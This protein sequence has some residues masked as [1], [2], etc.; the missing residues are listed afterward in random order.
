MQL[1]EEMVSR[2]IIRKKATIGVNILYKALR[3][4]VDEKPLQREALGR[5]KRAPV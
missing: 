5:Q 4:A 1:Q 2:E 3:I